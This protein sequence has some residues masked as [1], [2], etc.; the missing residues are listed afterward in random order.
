PFLSSS[1]RRHTR[2]KRD[3]SSDVCSSDLTPAPPPASTTP[4]ACSPRAPTPIR[5]NRPPGPRA[6]PRYS[7]PTR[8]WSATA[9]ATTRSRPPRRVTSCSSTTRAPTPRS[10][11]ARCRIPPG[12][13]PLSSCPSTRTAGPSGAPPPP[14]PGLR[15]PVARSSPPQERRHERDR[16]AP[17]PEEPRLLELRRSVLLLLRH[18]AARLHLPQP[19]ARGRGGDEPRQHRPAELG[20]GA[21][22]VLPPA[23]L[24]V[25]PGQ[26]RIPQA[27]VRL[28][29][30]R[31]RPDGTVLRLRLHTAGR[32]EPGAG[33]R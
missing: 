5:S 17:Q 19:L 18:L 20:H 1:R 2:S 26:A 10:R 8:R 25:H 31:R 32:A 33:R 6:R 24:R 3:W 15:R 30:A 23:R 27:P 21:D 29:G 7:S 13:P 16:A 11:A 4:W 9:R 14:A 28:R 12:T 22:R